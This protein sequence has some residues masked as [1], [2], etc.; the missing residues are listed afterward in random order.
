MSF[1]HQGNVKHSIMPYW[2]SFSYT[3]LLH[4]VKPIGIYAIPLA[5]VSSLSFMF[6][7]ADPTVCNG[8]WT[9][10]VKIK[11]ILKEGIPM[12]IIGLSGL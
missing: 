7:I 12:V 11:E 9:G 6:P 10:Y 8:I 2:S 1:N 5:I 3:R 4:R